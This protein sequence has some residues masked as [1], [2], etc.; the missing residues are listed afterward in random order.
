MAIGEFGEKGFELRAD[1][2]EDYEGSFQLDFSGIID[3]L[4]TIIVKV[5]KIII[6]GKAKSSS[7]SSSAS[8]Y[9][10]DEEVEEAEFEQPVSSADDASA[11]T[12]L[13]RVSTSPRPHRHHHH[14]RES[15]FKKRATYAA[16]LCFTAYLCCR[17]VA[18]EI[19]GRYGLQSATSGA[20][21]GNFDVQFT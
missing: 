16:T 4:F 5:T 8:L 7:V 15:D 9:D 2:E 10:S 20:A 3:E 13:P 19:K 6:K 14:K 18:D 21:P 17:V 1:I 12:A 11:P